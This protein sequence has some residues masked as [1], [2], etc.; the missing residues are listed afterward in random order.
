MDTVFSVT[1][2]YVTRLMSARRVM[3]NVTE[4]TQVIQGELPKQIHGYSPVEPSPRC[5]GLTELQTNIAESLKKVEPPPRDRGVES[6]HLLDAATERRPTARKKGPLGEVLTLLRQ[7]CPSRS[8]LGSKSIEKSRKAPSAR[9]EA[10]YH[11]RTFT[12]KAGAREYKVFVPSHANERKLPLIVML[13]GC[14]QDPD[15]FAAGTGMNRLAEEHGF[16]VAYPRQLAKA[17]QSG[18]WNWFNLADQMRDAGE[19]S[20]IAGITRAIIAEFDIDG[21]Q[22]YVAGHS[23]GG[24]M[25][26]IMSATYPE[27]YAATGI[28]SGLPYG[29]ATDIVSAFA[30]M[31]GAS[32]PA[33]PPQKKGQL[34][35][36]RG[37]VRTIVFHGA[38]DQTVHPSN[39]ETIFAAVRGGLTDLLQETKQDGSIGGRAYTRRVIA[40]ANGV[41]HAEHWVIDGLGHAW[42]GGSPDG[43][44]TDP[45]GPNASREML[46]FFLQGQA[47]PSTS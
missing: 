33:A 26:A 37:R 35:S 25:A 44:Q 15:D 40:D 39:A 31:R 8:G 7:A 28:H 36:P 1:M 18:C 3:K 11:A 34:D 2:R 43:S 12:C 45:R 22:V 17:N 21:E 9:Q 20:I 5:S 19:P 27:L 38:Y 16:V 46:R 29:S 6:V 13:H 32:R 24:A 4:A 30:V 14:T 23:A 10:A 47:R 42:S 41:P